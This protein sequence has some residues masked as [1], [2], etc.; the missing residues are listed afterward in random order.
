MKE[1][2][3]ERRREKEKGGGRGCIMRGHG[4]QLEGWREKRREG[5]NG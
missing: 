3:G 4:R 1:G 5:R 2:E